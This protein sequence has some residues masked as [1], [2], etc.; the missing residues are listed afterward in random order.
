[1]QTDSDI[2]NM[3]KRMASRTNAAGRT[4]LSTGSVKSL[5]ALAWWARDRVKC[6]LIVDHNQ[7]DAAA[8]EEAFE[9]KVVESQ[10]KDSDVTVKDL[11][12]FKPEDY[13]VHEDAFL[14]MLAQTPGAAR[15]PIHYVCHDA[16][17]PVNFADDNEERMYQMP[18]NEPAFERDNHMVYCKLKQFLISTDGY[19]WIEDP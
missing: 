10:T 8:L 18:L 6:G 1:M 2:E 5:Q 14:N 11:G 7:W 17:A 15:E 13:D 16:I 4:F 9:R 19:A 12:H 3:S